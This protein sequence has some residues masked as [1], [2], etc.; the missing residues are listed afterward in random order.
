MENGEK[1][2]LQSVDTFFKT[3]GASS[4]VVTTIFK[5]HEISHLNEIIDLINS[6]FQESYTTLKK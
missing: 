5:F 6:S 3:Y 1:L 4:N 2:G